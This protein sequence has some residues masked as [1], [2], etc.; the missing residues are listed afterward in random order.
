M[1]VNTAK[2]MKKKTVSKRRKLIRIIL[3]ILVLLFAA[4]G[5]YLQGKLKRTTKSP[6]LE[7]ADRNAKWT[8]DLKYLKE[9]LPQKHKNLFFHITKENFNKEMDLLLGKVEKYSDI[10]LK[11]EL[12]RVINLV[13]DSHTSIDISG[14]LMY[15]LGF[16]QFEDD[17]YLT[18]SSL[19]YRALWGEKLL[20]INGYSIKELKKMLEPYVS[21]DNEAISKNQFSNLLNCFEPL[22][23]A[24]VAKEEEVTYTFEASPEKAIKIKPFKREELQNIKLLNQEAEAL[25]KFPLPK[26]KQDMYWYEYIEDKKTM[27]VKYNS[28]SN[29]KEYPFSQFTKDVFEMVDSKKAEKLVVDFR[30]NGGGNSL[31]FRP[32]LKEIKKRETLNKKENL[33]VVVGRRTFSSAILNAMDL[34]KGTNAT[35]I[36][37]P[38][39]GKPNHFGEVKILQLSNVNISTYYSSN[40]FKTTKDDTDSLYPDAEVPLKAS[41]F[42]SGKDDVL[43]YI[44]SKQ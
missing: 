19:E 17:I 1:E 34:R 16:F 38:T 5:I 20:A 44:F 35:L 31:V 13:N 41:S 43:E 21:K 40:Y 28:C 18:N 7:N 3:L 6:I 4:S 9:K 2:Q 15:P 11:G 22:Q 42:F 30:D 10:E 14:N 32:F 26:Q 23:I 29:I 27:Y 12:A 36:G 24:G 33:Y 8:A 39:G 25:N 37:E